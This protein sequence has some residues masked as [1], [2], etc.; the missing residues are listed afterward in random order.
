M[1]IQRML[2]GMIVRTSVVAL[3]LVA[4]VVSV[5]AACSSSSSDAP[6]P[7]PG[8]DDDGGSGADGGYAADGAPIPATA[9]NGVKDADETD[10]DCGGTSGKACVTSQG[11]LVPADC[12]DGVCT[13]GTCQAPT[14]TDKV[15]NGD[16]SDVDCGGTKTGAPK[17]A[18]AKACSVHADCAS[19]GCSY[20]KKCVAIRSC[21]AHHGGDTCGP[22]LADAGHES[23]C[24]TIPGSIVDKYSVTAGRFRAMVE[25]TNGDLR[26]YI[27]AHKPAWWNDQW[28][29]YLPTML[30]N[31]GTAIDY[32]G[33]YQELGPLH[34]KLSDGTGAGGANEGCTVKN[35]GTR[36]YRLPDAINTRLMDNQNYSQDI[37]D[38]KPMNC[39]TAFMAAAFCA[40]DGGRLPS[41]PEWDV[42]WGADLYPWGATPAP[43]GWQNAYPTEAIAMNNPTYPTTTG[44]TH[45]AN[46][47]KNWWV[48]AAI[49]GTDYSLYIAEPGR[50][51]L[52]NSPSGHADM[53]GAVF[54]YQSILPGGNAL[55]TGWSVQG[56]K[57]G[58]WQ[59]HVIPYSTGNASAVGYSTQ[60]E[61]KYLALG[62]RCARD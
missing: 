37:L 38:E 40:W 55:G 4:S 20:A 29:A 16:E 45:R 60:A 59:E 3:A 5:V 18:V 57:S 32:T 24:T 39:V 54:N 53:A 49:V 46:Y 52:G 36:T 31:G 8:A 26:G 19:D 9:T 22:G 44:D 14:A 56:S 51:P 21:T 47:Y 35:I 43:A 17:C 33:M 6:S 7:G 23:C 10:V 62:M 28:T 25:R 58:S 61:Y 48:P 27:T 30:D 34:H 11:C 1:A 2:S 42:A 12:V 41:R 15:K 50:F 13:G